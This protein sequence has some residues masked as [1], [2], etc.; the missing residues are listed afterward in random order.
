MYLVASSEEVGNSLGRGLVGNG[1][2]D[3][4]GHVTMVALCR[5]SEFRIAVETTEGCKMDIAAE[6]G[7]SNVVALCKGLESQ[8]QCFA[9]FF[10]LSRGVVVVKI[11]K[12]VDASVEIIEQAT[13]DTEA[14]VQK[15]NGS[16]YR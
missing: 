15:A 9:L 5:D 6:D 12:Q 10:V 1:T 3:D 11:V 8:N 14:L 2:T 4:V 13:P 16:D 7:D